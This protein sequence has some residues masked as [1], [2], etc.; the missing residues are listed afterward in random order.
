MYLWLAIDVDRQL[1]WARRATEQLSPSIGDGNPALTLPLHVSLRMSFPIPKQDAPD[2]IRRIDAY[3]G[4]ILP[5]R[6]AARKIEKCGDTVR[7]RMRGGRML[8]KIHR[9]L[10]ALTQ[11]EFGIPPH[12]LD[13]DFV[14]HTTLFVHSDARAVDRAYAALRQIPLPKYLTAS[15]LLVGCSETGRADDYR[16]LHATKLSPAVMR[17]DPFDRQ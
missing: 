3:F 17:S 2:L 8:R 16:V 12:P 4:T 14:F 9:D 6:I 11:R 15:R 7:I 1:A 13:G 5:F 10:L